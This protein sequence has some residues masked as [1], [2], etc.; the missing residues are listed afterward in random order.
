MQAHPLYGAQDFDGTV[1]A[2]KRDRD[3][4]MLRGMITVNV[5]FTNFGQAQRAVY[6]LRADTSKPG[7][8]LRIFMVEHDGWSYP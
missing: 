4:P 2:P 8:P 5:D 7:A 6:R 1:N 3:Q